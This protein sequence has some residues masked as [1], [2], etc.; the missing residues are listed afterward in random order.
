MKKA[1]DAYVLWQTDQNNLELMGEALRLV[2]ED[3]LKAQE[4]LLSKSNAKIEIN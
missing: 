4:R 3:G 2:V 1:Q